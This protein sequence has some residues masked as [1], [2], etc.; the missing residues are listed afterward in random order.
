MDKKLKIKICIIMNLIIFGSMIFSF[1]LFN[2]Y[3]SDYFRFGWSDNFTFVSLNI[4]S[5]WKYFLLCIFISLINVADVLTNEVV[6]PILYFSTYNPDKKIITEFT[7]SELQNYS[8]IIFLIHTL[9]KFLQVLIIISQIDV[10]FISIIS[11]QISGMI[12]INFLLNEKS[13][14]NKIK[15]TNYNSIGEIT[16]LYDK[17]T[18]QV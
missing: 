4:D 17:V 12:F 8:N 15:L 6:D 5:G 13:F 10:A 16:P 2:N 9:K 18:L 11:S 14:D 1:F 7:K 3:S